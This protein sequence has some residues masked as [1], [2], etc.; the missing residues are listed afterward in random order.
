ML[1]LHGWCYSA[2]K[3][4]FDDDCGVDVDDDEGA[5]TMQVIW[6]PKIALDG[7]DNSKLYS[8]RQADPDHIWVIESKLMMPRPDWEFRSR[9]HFSQGK[10][11]QCI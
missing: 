6:R 7:V 2:W 5:P 1:F 10:L 8:D 4:A 9:S 11:S 3:I